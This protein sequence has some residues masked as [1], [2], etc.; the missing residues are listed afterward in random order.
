MLKDGD[1]SRK[2]RNI[3]L[4]NTLWY[5]DTHISQTV[6]SVMAYKSRHKGTATNR[7]KTSPQL[8]GSATPK[9]ARRT[10]LAAERRLILFNKPMHVLCQFTGEAGD[11]T[12]KDFID[13]PHVYA[14]G[15]L[16]KDS[17]GLLVLTND[18]QLQA[19]ISSPKFKQAKVYYVLVEGQPTAEALTALAAG[20]ELND[21]K[22]L[23]AEVE[24]VSEPE[25]V[26]PRT[27]PV[28]VRKHIVDTWL[29]ITLKEGRNRQVRRMTAHIGHPTLRLIRWQIGPWT[30]ADLPPGSYREVTL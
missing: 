14:A 5:N 20:V 15:R 22:T 17:E 4:V 6:L 8:S 28:R 19:K 25:W 21:G 11:R 2:V 3:G 10:A 16:D 1:T 18:G 29:R 23:P 7:A 24:A 9:G 27:P 13:I 12:L 26:W 30:I